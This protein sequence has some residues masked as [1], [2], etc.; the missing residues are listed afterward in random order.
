MQLMF[1]ISSRTLGKSMNGQLN[2]RIDA[3][4]EN[5]VPR[6][7]Q[8]DKVDHGEEF[9]PEERS[10]SVRLEVERT[11]DPAQNQIHG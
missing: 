11:A 3:H 7:A 5:H 6:Q 1:P 8:K 2:Y 10:V 4:D 9:R